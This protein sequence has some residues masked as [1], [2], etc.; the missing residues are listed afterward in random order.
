MQRLKAPAQIISDTI[1]REQV[2]GLL[3]GQPPGRPYS[4]MQNAT[5]R[6]VSLSFLLI[7]VSFLAAVPAPSAHR[8][9][10]GATFPGGFRHKRSRQRR[11]PSWVVAA[12][13]TASSRRVRGGEVRAVMVCAPARLAHSALAS[14][15]SVSGVSPPSAVCASGAG[16][17]AVAAALR[18]R[19]V[20]VVFFLVLAMFS[21]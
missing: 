17:S 6:A 15:A 9:P 7:V 1:L 5:K 12:G 11:P 8:P 4:S 2:D 3:A 16:V 18:L 10:G 14:G 21:S 20:R 13:C 19:R